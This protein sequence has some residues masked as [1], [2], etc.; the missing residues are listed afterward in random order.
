LFGVVRLRLSI[1]G[2][3]FLC[4]RVA[5]GDCGHAG[6]QRRAGWRGC[7]QAAVLRSTISVALVW[8]PTMMASRWPFSTLANI[9]STSGWKPVVVFPMALCVLSL[10]RGVVPSEREDGRRWSSRCFSGEGLDRVFCSQLWVLGAYCEDLV[11][12]FVSF[13]VLFVTCTS[14]ICNQCSV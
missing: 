14:A 12:I 3:P 5:K 10:P 9:C 6:S 4:R 11:I 7:S 8:L 2:C 13:R 1:L